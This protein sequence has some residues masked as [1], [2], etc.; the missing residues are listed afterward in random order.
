MAGIWCGKLVVIA[1]I[2]IPGKR[3][4]SLSQVSPV[5][6]FPPKRGLPSKRKQEYEARGMDALLLM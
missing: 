3:E 4:P 1:I 5:M 6:T 2:T